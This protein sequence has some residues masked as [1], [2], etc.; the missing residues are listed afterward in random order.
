[1]TGIKCQKCK[2]EKPIQEFN[3]SGYIYFIPTAWC[4]ECITDT[5]QGNHKEVQPNDRL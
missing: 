2:K 1:M 4:T 5:Q 3:D